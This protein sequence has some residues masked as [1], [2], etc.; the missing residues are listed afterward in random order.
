VRI[1]LNADLGEGVGDD[2]ALL[3]VVSSANVATGAHGGGG[4]VLRRAVGAAA[5]RGV[6]I[7]AH[8]S[9]RDR[10]GFGRR[11]ELAPLRAD[12]AARVRFVADL[13]EQV[14]AVAAEAERAGVPLAHVKPHGA[15]YNDAAA[16][17]LAAELVL[18]AV[19]EVAHRC[20]HPVALFALAGGEVAARG[21][22]AGVDVVAEGF[23]DRAY[24]PTGHLAP[25][26]DPGA[27]HAEVAAMVAQAR[28]LA[29]GR[30]RAV[31]GSTVDLAV[32][33]V[34]VHGDT[35]GA[36]A[37]ARAVRQGLQESGW[38]VRPRELTALAYA[39]VAERLLDG[40]AFHGPAPGV[41]PFGD[42]GML[43]A[44]ADGAPTGTAWV[45]SAAGAARRVWQDASIRHGLGSVLVSLD[46]PV[47][48]P[49]RARHQLHAAV[50]AGM[51]LGERRER[52]VRPGLLARADGRGRAGQSDRA[53]QA[54]QSDRAGQ[55]GQAD[56]RGQAGQS[57]RAGQAGQADRGVEHR[58]EVRYDGEDVGEVAAAL[59]V[60]IGELTARHASTTWTVAALG[61]SPGFGYLTC[62]DPLF[63]GIAR[64]SQPRTRVPAGA[65][66]VAAGMC[67][68]YPSAS[69]GGWQ[70]IG[71]TDEVLFD[72]LSVTP[73]RL[74][75]GD[76]VRFVVR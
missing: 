6:A 41:A 57:D 75:P 15:L 29:V 72:A 8:P 61:F 51:T 67:A 40:W 31:D 7:G 2:A 43:V 30:V 47:E 26:A 74:A 66:A 11:S 10:A 27:V 56:G 45:L 36:V 63:A 44:A 76:R 68:V 49:V 73:A 38:Q 64:R 32:G 13:V 50:L 48:D 35:P 59:G 12:A 62:D 69:P 28:D 71:S 17:P 22:A 19:T 70:L 33:S 3:E 55:A 37:A 16:D 24:L 58:I 65:L 42:R 14:M 54:G 20:A 53:G 60:S 25:R 9:Y 21:A 5:E 4:A 23:A 52:R 34:C 39:R 46:A 18:A 1:D